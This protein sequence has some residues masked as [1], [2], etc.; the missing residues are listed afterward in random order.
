MRIVSFSHLGSEEL[1]QLGSDWSNN[2]SSGLIEQLKKHT[3]D[4]GPAED[5]LL[6]YQVIL[7]SWVSLQVE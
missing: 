3:E 1:H 7:F 4:E 6:A 2:R 5:T